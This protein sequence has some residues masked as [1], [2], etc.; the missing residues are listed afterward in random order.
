MLIIFF[1]LFYF[2]F[3][4][5]TKATDPHFQQITVTFCF[6]LT[7]YSVIFL[8][9][10]FDD[11][12]KLFIIADYFGYLSKKLYLYKYMFSSKVLFLHIC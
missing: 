6:N 2:V 7:Y 12:N 1:F 3:R 5:P 8:L 11:N 10:L 4:R 9:M